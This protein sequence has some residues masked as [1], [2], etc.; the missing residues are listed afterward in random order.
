MGVI[1]NHHKEFN[2]LSLNKE[3]LYIYLKEL[4]LTYPTSY[5]KPTKS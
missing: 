1:L 3:L 4:S 5:P 2:Y